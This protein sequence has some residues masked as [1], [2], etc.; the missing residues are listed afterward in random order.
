VRSFQRFFAT[1][2]ALAAFAAPAAGVYAHG[3]PVQVTVVNNALSVSG[4]LADSAGFAPMIFVESTETGDPFGEVNLPGFGRSIIWQIP[5]YEISGL[6][7]HSGLFLDPISRPFAFS[8][9]NPVEYRG[10][11]YWDPQSQVV[12]TTPAAN[13]VQIRKS[14]TA[15][16]TISPTSGADP[17]ALQ[18]AEPLASDE[19]FHNHLVAYALNEDSPP[20]DGAYGFFARVTSN[21]YGPSAAFLVVLNDAVFDYS[22]MVPAALAINAA[23]FLPGDYN[24]DDRVDAADYV[25][26]KK[27]FGSTTML[28]ADGSGNKTVDQA[29]Y[30]VWRR[31]FGLAVSAGGLAVGNVPEPSGSALVGAAALLCAAAFR[32]RA[33]SFASSISRPRYSIE[34]EKHG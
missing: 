25:V 30:D 32:F 26:W 23:A 14:T 34:T 24:H 17:P 9:S 20:P 12:A 4:G 21:Q 19:G 5:G 28:G 1:A 33:L 16:V 18:I 22:K 13:P 15:N 7:E 29:D 27:T 6:D 31:N 3:T 8:T 2:I 10:L 11:W